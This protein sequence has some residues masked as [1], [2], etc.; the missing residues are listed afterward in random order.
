MPN[1]W[2]VPGPATGQL[3]TMFFFVLLEQFHSCPRKRQRAWSGHLAL[4]EFGTFR[5]LLSLTPRVSWQPLSL[6]ERFQA[7]ISR[8]MGNYFCLELFFF[9]QQVLLESFAMAQV[10]V[11]SMGEKARSLL[12]DLKSLWA[13]G[14][15]F[16]EA[17]EKIFSTDTECEQAGAI[18]QRET[19]SNNNLYRCLVLLKPGLF[20]WNSFSRKHHL[21]VSF[22]QLPVS[23]SQCH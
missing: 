5:F 19:V 22:S 16:E 3:L 21:G 6:S 13:E 18:L 8:N 15:F 14:G 10:G 7:V 12:G 4:W 17:A 9:H 23:P 2:S 1:F 20:C 11:T